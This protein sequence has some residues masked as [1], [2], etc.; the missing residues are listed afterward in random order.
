M[1]VPCMQEILF[2]HFSMAGHN[3][4]LNDVSITFIDKLIHLILYGEKITGDKHLKQWLRT[5]LVLKT[6]SDGCFCVYLF[7]W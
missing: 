7:T 4:L 3:G 1:Q 6:M 5:D 2:S